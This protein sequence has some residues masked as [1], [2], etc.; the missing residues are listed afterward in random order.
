M[1]DSNDPRKNPLKRKFEGL[2]NQVTIADRPLNKRRGL[3]LEFTISC[4]K[5][6]INLGGVSS[7]SSAPPS[8]ITPS[9]T[10]D[11]A[12]PVTS[13][14]AGFTGRGVVGRSEQVLGIFTDFLD[15]HLLTAPSISPVLI[16]GLASAGTEMTVAFNQVEGPAQGAVDFLQH[17]S[18]I[19][20]DFPSS[21]LPICQTNPS[22]VMP[23]NHAESS[24][25][26]QADIINNISAQYVNTGPNYGTINQ[27]VDSNIQI[28]LEMIR[29]EQLVEKIYKW[30]SPPKE[31]VNYNAA[32]AILE[33][34][35]DTCQWFLKGNTF[36]GWL[37]QPG[38]LWI[39]GK[40]GSGKTILS[41]AI[42]HDIRQKFNSATAYFFFDGRDLQKDFQLHDKLM[43]SLI[44]QFSV[45]CD[46]RVPK[47][48]VNLYASCAN[49]H[50]EPTLGDLQNTLQMI[51]D[52]FSSTFIILD[53]LDECTER[54]KLLKWIQTSI[55]E[56][57]E[58]LGLHLIVTSRPEQEI[59][60]KFKSSCYI[61]LVEESENHD[62]VT[63][64]DYQLRS[65]S[66]LQKWDCGTQKEIKLKLME[67]A[68]GM[69]RW[70]ALQLNEL[71]KCRTKTDLKR[72]LAD[73]PKGLD[74]T[75]D[76]ILLGINEKDHGYAKTFL[77]W[78]S[79]AVR[80][81]TLKELATTASVD[82]YAE[83]GPEYKSDNELQ[84]IKD[85]LKICSS[86]I[87]M[88]EGFIKLSHFSVKEYLVSEYVQNHAVKQV[89]DFSFSEELSHSVISQICLAYLLQFHTSEPLDIDVDVSFP[90]AN[91]C[92][93]DE[94]SDRG[95]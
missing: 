50:Q 91:I 23:A 17:P 48:L 70:V 62:V 42:I 31:S 3:R 9:S 53:A 61:D 78:L 54:E 26:L 59:E 67:Q 30:L 82:L 75:Y 71:K 85:V 47:V 1:S 27:G 12:M 51:L 68:D 14:E 79:F 2:P 34:Q 64:L 33:S 90:L 11:I 92:I 44:W 39:K 10:A 69:F 29:D 18:P 57:D 37:K 65:D 6:N 88:S 49:G 40:S 89:R 58:N 16:E 56:K 8:S 80:P 38:F 36:Y 66:G 95:K 22:E 74:K 46:G 52:G 41:S 73:L 60:D 19:L 13:D 86:F 21:D 94:A 5:I 25:N 81:L 4:Y 43:R 83:N 28:T 77:Q 76:Q 24:T 7:P 55:L 45:K 84:D 15:P 20:T 72:Q 35:P 63:Y 93:D 87:M 32:L